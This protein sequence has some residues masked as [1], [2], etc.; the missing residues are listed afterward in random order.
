VSEMS[1]F[2][3]KKRLQTYTLVPSHGWNSPPF[4]QSLQ[5]TIHRFR[6]SGHGGKIQPQNWSKKSFA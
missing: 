5:L 3:H 2:K 4:M 1:E 6:G